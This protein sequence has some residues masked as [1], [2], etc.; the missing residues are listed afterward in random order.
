MRKAS[1]LAA[2]WL[3][4]AAMTGRGFSAPNDC[5]SADGV[6]IH[7]GQSVVPAAQGSSGHVM[8]IF[9]AC[10]DGRWLFNGVTP[11][12]PPTFGRDYI[13]VNR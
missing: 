6:T 1:V 4:V 2:G 11:V 12:A 5:T 9:F 3:F 10:R 7:S 8:S 13:V